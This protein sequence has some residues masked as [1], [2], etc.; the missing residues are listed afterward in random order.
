MEQSNDLVAVLAEAGLDTE[1]VRA[2]AL[3][4]QFSEL[5]GF[6]ASVEAK[7]REIVVTDESQLEEMASARELRLELKRRRVDLEKTRKELK[8]DIIKEGRA[9]DSTAKWLTDL[10]AP[11]EAYLDEQEHFV[12]RKRAAEE[13]ERRRKADELL[14]QQEERDR[15]EREK[16][17]K[18]ERERIQRE[19]EENRKR[20]EEAE[21]KERE[22]AVANAKREAEEKAAAERAEYERKLTA[23]AMVVCPHCGEAFDSREHLKGGGV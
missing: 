2:R 9:I 3:I 6:A 17:E 13:E 15:I 11:T 14:R 10:I 7:A 12:E 20:A 23:A 16:A 8:A 5:A 19:S 4:D 22:S 1:S 21:R 18:E